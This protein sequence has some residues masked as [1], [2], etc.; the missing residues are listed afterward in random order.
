MVNNSFVYFA[1]V[2]SSWLFCNLSIICIYS[3]LLRQIKLKYNY[4]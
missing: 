4:G 2:P 3:K 1:N